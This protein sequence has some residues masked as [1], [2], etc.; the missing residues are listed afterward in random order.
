MIQSARL[1]GRLFSG[2]DGEAQPAV[3]TI[4]ENLER[5][6]ERA[7]RADD[8]SAGGSHERVVLFVPGPI[9][10]ADLL[11]ENVKHAGTI[12][13]RQR[14]RTR[15]RPLTDNAGTIAF[16]IFLLVL[17]WFVGDG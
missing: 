13:L 5:R 1:N 15:F 11:R 4:K 12:R 9:T 14:R 3:E 16:V 8:R 6:L 7:S 17:A 10:E 2:R